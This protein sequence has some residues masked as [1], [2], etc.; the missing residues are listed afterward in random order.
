MLL[1]PAYVPFAF[2]I[3]LPF[4]QSVQY[5]QQW[6]SQREPPPAIRFVLGQVEVK[7]KGA[8]APPES[9]DGRR[10][11]EAPHPRLWRYGDHSSRTPRYPFINICHSSNVPDPCSSLLVS[12]YVSFMSTVAAQSAHI[13]QELDAVARDWT[14]PPPDAIFTLRVPVEFASFQAAVRRSSHRR[15]R[16]LFIPPPLASRVWALYLRTFQ[17]LSFRPRFC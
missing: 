3:P 1:S 8:R 14:K 4:S 12:W 15:L 10:T 11:H 16:M 2:S 5:S 17:P 6:G 9:S 13:S 7:A